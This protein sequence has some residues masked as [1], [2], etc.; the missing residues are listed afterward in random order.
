[1]Q[2][3]ENIFNLINN[4][5]YPC[6]ILEKSGEAWSLSYKNEKMAELLQEDSTEQALPH[7]L[8]NMLIAH[9]NYS[10]CE[11][12]TLH[13]FEI[14]GSLYNIN[15]ELIENRLF[16]FFVEVPLHD[17][18]ESLPFHDGKGIYDS[19]IA[20]LNTKGELIDANESFCALIEAEKSEIEGKNFFKNFIPG[21]IDTL[22]H[23]LEHVC[24]L[25]DH[26]EHFVTP[27]KSLGAHT[28]RIN[29]HVSKISWHD[30][31]YVIAVGSDISKF[32]KE[33]TTLKK[34][35]HSIQVGFNYFPFGIAYMNAKG[36]FTNMNARF[37]KMFNVDEENEAL[38]FDDIKLLK[39]HIGFD[40][41]KEYVKPIKEM[42]YSIQH[43]TKNRNYT[44]KVDVRLLS[45]R[46]D[47]S[48]FYIL[49]VQKIKT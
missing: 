19:I 23:Y 35:L 4:L 46:K 1:M 43:K 22:N 5:S 42:S 27:L 16:A 40:N 29:W 41:M 28:Y 12:F 38:N 6:L 37:I 32:T 21:N 18:F 49:V 44:I 33:N 36:K 8:N 17:L 31:T 25:N 15:F 9:E 39:K 48:K 3:P 13:H 7:S 47:S 11:I 24:S 10:T 20:V 45:G 34:K 30:E 14:F 26:H 2:T